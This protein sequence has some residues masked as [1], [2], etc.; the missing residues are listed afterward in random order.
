[1]TRSIVL[2][3][4]AIFAVFSGCA[5]NDLKFT[6][7][8]QEIDGLKE[9]D[10][11]LF[12]GERIGR[13]A[14]LKRTSEGEYRVEVLVQADFRDAVTT[15]SVFQILDSPE[16]E[17]KKAIQMSL[18]QKGGNP[19]EEGTVVGGIPA[20]SSWLEQ[21]E[22]GLEKGLEEL[23]EQ[24]EKF[25]EQLKKIPE[26]EEFQ[27]LREELQRLGKELKESGDDAR[28]KLEKELLP[29]LKQKLEELRKKL[30]E[31]KGK[32]KKPGVEV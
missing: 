13:V 3:L 24:Y 23:R 11:I 1:M 22:A 20:K 7:T 16:T 31:Q 6:I 14:A 32:E 27:H 2:F 15:Y 9:E 19:L 18:T 28:E 10:P 12:E 4:V 25:S 5:E 26:S 30:E 8:Y 17:G 21:T 29:Q